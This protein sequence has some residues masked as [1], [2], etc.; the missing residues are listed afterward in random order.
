MDKYVKNDGCGIF[1]QLG[2]GVGDLDPRSQFRDGF[3]EFVKSLSKETIKKIILVEPNPLNIIKLKE[4]WKDYPQ[5]EIY[6][7]AITPNDTN[8]NI[9]NFYYCPDD[10]PHYHIASINQ[11]HI[12]NSRYGHNCNLIKI[13]V[14]TQNINSFLE[15]KVGNNIE[16]LGMDIE[17]LDIPVLLNINFDKFKIKYLSFEH[18]C[19]KEKKDLIFNHLNNNNLHY[20][21]YG[22]DHN[23]YDYLFVNK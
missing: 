15:E 7:L 12:H 10:G 9:S 21:G 17:G 2:A 5:A 16:L 13:S 6:E 19:L 8:E 18:L 1:V 3:T 20:L 22:L 11:S 4:C 14:K 23:G